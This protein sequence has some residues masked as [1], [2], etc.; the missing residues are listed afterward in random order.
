[1]SNGTRIAAGGLLVAALALLLARLFAGDVERPPDVP[2]P[3]APV[4][5][6]PERAA[7]ADVGEREVVAALPAVVEQPL[8][9]LP[10]ADLSHPYRFDLTVHVRSR[11]GLPVADASVFVAPPMCGFS[12][13]PEASSN[14]GQ[15]AMA[16]SG[17]QPTMA[18]T[19]A[20]LAAGVLQPM[21]RVELRA[22]EPSSLAVGVRSRLWQATPDVRV[23]ERS[24]AER[25]RAARRVQ[26][27]RS[28]VERGGRM[29]R[30]DELD[31]LCGRTM[32]LF[33]SFSCVE[34]HE[35]D[36]V[37]GYRSIAQSGPFAAGLHPHTG[38]QDLGAWRP[39]KEEQDRTRKERAAEQ[40]RRLRA[41]SERRA[42]GGYVRGV[43]TDGAGRAVEG[44]AVLVV[45]EHGQ[46][47]HAVESGAD[48]SYRIG[49]LTA[50]QV[51]LLAN[52]ARAGLGMATV[53][54]APGQ[55]TEWSPS[56]TAFATVSGTVR[57]VQGRGL[58]GWFVELQ[59]DE[60]DWAAVAETARDG[61]FAVHGVPGPV[62]TAVWTRDA[63]YGAPLLHGTAAL[64]DAQPLALGLHPDAPTRARLRVHVGVP[65]ELGEARVEARLLQVRTGYV[66]QLTALGHEDGFAT[67][68]L[69]GGAYRVQVG[70]AGAGWLE[71]D[72]IVLDGRGLMDVG[73]MVLPGPGRVRL[74]AVGEVELPH[75]EALAF[76]R[77]TPAVDVRSLHRVDGDA[78]ELPPGEHVLVWTEGGRR[79]AVAFEVRSGVTTDVLIGP[80]A[81][82]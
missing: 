82:R 71:S 58:G 45:D 80:P 5:S 28:R 76:Y 44:A 43:L 52:G 38:F 42:R 74:R 9:T 39:A 68:P 47:E 51:E 19:V 55:D 72:N 56:L 4:A 14:R 26:Y 63:P 61:S 64:V 48:G 75:R 54:V 13:W 12:R 37:G 59:R 57:D 41:E 77:R 25:Q 2:V 7:P 16:W 18:V 67:E 50:G 46:V 33:E 81:P 66:A 20:V 11:L 73:R 22:G 60:G 15:V 34:C 29:Q 23:V 1:M 31:V 32:L 6:E 53:T 40:R 8:E 70:A 65:V 35:A 49:P 21:R 79:R 30:L 10:E 24:D 27:E 36:R 69:P 62:V 78:F 17:R 3:A